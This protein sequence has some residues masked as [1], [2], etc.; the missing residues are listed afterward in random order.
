AMNIQTACQ[1]KNS[2][3][4]LVFG[5]S[6]LQH[7]ALLNEIKQLNISSKDELPE[8]WFEQPRSLNDDDNHQEM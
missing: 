6:P 7:F 2:L 1:I 3:Y 4:A 8:D 5:Q